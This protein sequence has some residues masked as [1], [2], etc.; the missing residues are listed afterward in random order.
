MKSKL[1]LSLILIS[2]VSICVAGSIISKPKVIQMPSAEALT[3]RALGLSINIED[4][5]RLEI[6]DAFAERSIMESEIEKEV[7]QILA[8]RWKEHLKMMQEKS[9]D[10]QFS[11][12]LIAQ[13]QEYERIRKAL[14]PVIIMIL[15]T[16]D[17][18]YKNQ[19]AI[20]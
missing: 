17:R 19:H 8:T 3:D 7:D 10:P 5:V 18:K 2:T 4:L 20:Q 6:F 1:I 12:Q 15:C 14:K 16:E 13:G 9:R 11:E